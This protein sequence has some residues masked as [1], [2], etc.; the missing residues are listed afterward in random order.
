MNGWSS[1]R[2]TQLSVYPQPVIWYGWHY[3]RRSLMSWVGVIPKEG[4]T[5]PRKR[6][7]GQGPTL[8][9]IQVYSRITVLIQ[10]SQFVVEFTL[11]INFI[12]SMR[13]I[14]SYQKIKKQNQIKQHT[15]LIIYGKFHNL[16]LAGI[17]IPKPMKVTAYICGVYESHARR[18]TVRQQVL[19][20]YIDM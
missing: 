3:A 9:S 2:K 7:G 10:T 16:K 11:L 20:I 14:N 1:P 15:V 8:V 17:L 6:I 12:F 5:R 4:R 19:H 18:H 13:K